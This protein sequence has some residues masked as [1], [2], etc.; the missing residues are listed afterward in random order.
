MFD[1]LIGANRNRPRLRFDIMLASLSAFPSFAPTPVAGTGAVNARASTTMMAARRSARSRG[2][3]CCLAGPLRPPGAA[4]LGGS[5]LSAG[6]H[7]NVCGHSGARRD[8]GRPHP[9]RRR[10]ADPHGFLGPAEP[11]GGGLLEPGQ[12]G[13][14]RLAAPRRDQARPRRDGRLRRL[15]FESVW[16]SNFT[17]CSP[18]T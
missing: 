8:Q 6:S 15:L 5:M 3:K 9:S 13:D 16:K 18:S 4:H 1:G 11:R 7:L 14:D 10:A 17:S 12:R 2:K